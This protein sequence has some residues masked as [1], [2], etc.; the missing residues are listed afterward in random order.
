MTDREASGN[1]DKPLAIDIVSDVV[2]PW[3]FIGKRKLEQALSRRPERRVGLRWRPFQL[4]PTIP[5]GGIDRNLYLER[6]FGNAARVAE[7]QARVREAG[8]EVGIPFA[9]EKIRK[10]PNTLDAHRLIR[11]AHSTGRQTQVKE[12]LLRLYFLDGGDL[13]DQAALIRVGEENGLDR[14]VMTQLLEDGSD[15]TAVQEEIA[16]AVRLGVS[17]VPFFIFDSKFAV[18]GAQS[19]NVLV[20]AID[21]T[22][23]AEPEVATA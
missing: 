22:L 23:Q 14:R 9:F 4:D 10:S 8:H 11:W 6:K 2:C 12:A 21:K 19:A 20:A 18:P 7:I 17:G 1:G 13:G 15:V 16:T 3:C 5:A